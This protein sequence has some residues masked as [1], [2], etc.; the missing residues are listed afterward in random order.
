MYGDLKPQN[1]IVDAEDHLKLTDFGLSK[2]LNTNEL[3]K[4]SQGT[5]EYAAPEIV[6]GEGYDH[7][8]D[9]W[10]LGI[11]LYELYMGTTPFDCLEGNI[12][13]ILK[14]LVSK[15]EINLKDLENACSDKNFI[16]L[17]T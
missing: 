10:A 15:D 8:V 1:I 2:Q 9:F 11:T 16:D 14:M 4:A 6:R 17:I 3:T 5:P 12:G 13:K 7:R